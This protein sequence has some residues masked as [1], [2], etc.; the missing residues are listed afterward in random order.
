[1]G[2]AGQA[3]CPTHG[4]APDRVYIIKPMLPWAGCALTAPFQPYPW[5]SGEAHRR[6]LSV[7]L[8]LGLP[9][10]GVTRYPCPVEP[11]LSSSG[12][13]RFPSA[14]VRP[15]RL[16]SILFFS[17]KVK[18]KGKEEFGRAEVEQSS[19]GGR[20][21]LRLRWT[22]R[23]PGRMRGKNLSWERVAGRS[24]D[25]CGAVPGRAWYRPPTF[26]NRAFCFEPLRRRT[27]RAAGSRPYGTFRS[28][29]SSGKRRLFSLIRQGLWPCHLPRRGRL[30]SANSDLS[31]FFP[32]KTLYWTQPQRKGRNDH[33]HGFQTQADHPL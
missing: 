7:A 32:Q 3:Y 33:E 29:G 11:G 4:V 14:A 22:G 27:F 15:S 21:P 10:A 31:C 5:A 24:P 25:G 28:S 9:P 26:R 1:M 8:V 6:Y 16:D 23:S 20:L 12:S 30:P 2:T 19:P 13:F 18:Q 17:G